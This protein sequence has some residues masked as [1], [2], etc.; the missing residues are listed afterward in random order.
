MFLS[1]SSLVVI[2]VRNDAR[3][4]KRYYGYWCAWCSTWVDRKDIQ[5]DDGHRTHK[6]CGYVVDRRLSNKPIVCSPPTP[7]VRDSHQ[8]HQQMMNEFIRATQ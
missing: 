3:M 2:R 6:D 1:L 4:N 5:D 7:E 8:A